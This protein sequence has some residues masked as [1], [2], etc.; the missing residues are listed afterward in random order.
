MLLVFAAA[1]GEHGAVSRGRHPSLDFRN[2]V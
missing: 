1:S 2:G